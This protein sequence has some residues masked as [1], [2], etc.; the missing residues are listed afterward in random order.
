MGVS[1]QAVEKGADRKKC[2]TKTVKSEPP[3]P[4]T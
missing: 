2:K 3:S 1:Q 4:K